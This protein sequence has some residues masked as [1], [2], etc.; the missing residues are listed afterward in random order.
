MQQ[1]PSPT[2]NILSGLES[3]SSRLKRVNYQLQHAS[4]KIHGSSPEAI[5]KELSSPRSV[6][7]WMG[8]LDQIITT[9]ESLADLLTE[10]L[11]QTQ[12]SV[13]QGKSSSGIGTDVRR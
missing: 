2:V 6:V 1:A 5:A 13:N 12:Q 4:D 9:S 3:F 10:S 8:D 11:G 7:E